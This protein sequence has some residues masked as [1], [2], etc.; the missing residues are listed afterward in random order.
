MQLGR[1]GALLLCAMTAMG[2]DGPARVRDDLIAAKAEAMQLRLVEVEQQLE[3]AQQVAGLFVLEDAQLELVVLETQATVQ[4]ARDE[5]QQLIDDA[6]EEVE[7]L[8]QM[9]V[10]NV[11]RWQKTLQELKHAT[12]KNYEMLQEIE[13]E[14]AEVARLETAVRAQTTQKEKSDEEAVSGTVQEPERQQEQEMERQLDTS[15]NE[16]A[17]EQGM[18]RKTPEPFDKELEHRRNSEA[19]RELDARYSE[20]AGHRSGVLG[21]LGRYASAERYVIKAVV[22]LYRQLVLP[23]AVIIGFFF[24]LTMVIGR[25]K[26]MQHTRRNQRVMYSGY[27]KGVRTKPKQQ[28]ESDLDDAA[29]RPLLHR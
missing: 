8:Q 25:Y 3:T 7:R 15:S 4:V 29:D 21:F 6:M 23:V 17:R 18:E 27:P 13:S 12:R 16:P 19:I 28:S 5:V 24:V 11:T 20:G 26:V 9:A 14:R 1:R 10:E 2:E 22:T